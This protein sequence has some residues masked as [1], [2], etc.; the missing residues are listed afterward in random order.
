MAGKGLV[1]RKVAVRCWALL[2]MKKLHGLVVPTQ[3]VVPPLSNAPD[4]PTK[5]KPGA[6]VTVR[7]P[8]WSL[9]TAVTHDMRQGGKVPAGAMFENAT[10]PGAMPPR[11]VIWRFF[12][13]ATYG[14][15]NGPPL[16]PTPAGR[17]TVVPSSAAARARSRRPLPVSSRVPPPA[18]DRPRR[19]TMTP[20]E[21]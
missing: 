6:G 5:T 19:P 20:F 8:R 3:V 7:V 15:T 16:P 4:Q 12:F 18:A 13:A 17:T 1:S 10:N 11:M 9:S 14:P 2:D 21:A